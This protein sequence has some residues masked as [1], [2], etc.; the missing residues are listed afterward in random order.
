MARAV[1]SESGS[2]IVVARATA[3]GQAPV[4]I[5]RASGPDLDAFLERL[6][7]PS[8]S[9]RPE[10]GRLVLGRL[11]DAE[12]EFDEALAVLWKAPHSYTGE[13]VVE[14]HTH[15]SPAIVGRLLEACVAAGA[16]IARPGEFTRRAYSNGRMDLAQA[17]AV[18]D[19]IASQTEA[20]GRAALA[21]LSGGLSATLHAIR[22]AL[23][24]VVAELEAH[25]DFPDEGLETATRERIGAAIDDCACRVRSLIESST[26][27][28]RLKDGARVVLAGPPNA[29]KSSLFN[30]LLRRERALVTP[31]AGTT[32]DTIEA[33]IDLAGVPV[34]LV[35]TAGLRDDAEEIEAMGIGRARAELAGA[36]L[37]LFLAD[38]SRPDD[39]LAEYALHGAVPHVLVFTKT[40]LP[41]SREPNVAR[42]PGCRRVVRISCETKE[43]VGELETAILEAI[44]ASGEDAGA[45]VTSRRHVH[46]LAESVASLQRAGE[47][48]A[49]SLSP[50]FIVVDLT[51]AVASLDLITGRGEL[52]EDVLDAIFSTFCLGK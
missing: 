27:G 6:F 34:T 43:G 1:S 18:C 3:A 20:A 37:T 48:V 32:R 28:M 45:L 23:V 25:I 24:P 40:D 2:D 19:L 30:L 49:S 4:A 22:D 8:S 42:G 33:D 15:G 44:G 7:K 50:E 41:D 9:A 46:A 47:G 13:D 35:D 10:P 14:F 16:R 5:V 36:D 12:G 17:E 39:A 21:Q 51:E 31:H 52:D 38:S 29:G 26:R 11:A